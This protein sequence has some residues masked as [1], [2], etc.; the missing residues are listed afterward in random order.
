V[1]TIVGTAVNG[2]AAWALESS[3]TASWTY[4]GPPMFALVTTQLGH[5]GGLHDEYS[6]SVAATI[7]SIT[8]ENPDGSIN[9]LTFPNDPRQAWYNWV[10]D[11]LVSATFVLSVIS[12][13]ASMVAR[14]DF[15]A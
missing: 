5:V 7:S 9:V 4:D 12:G 10:G 11:A 13:E 1:A 15:W 6:G 8:T 3:Y 14:L 2:W